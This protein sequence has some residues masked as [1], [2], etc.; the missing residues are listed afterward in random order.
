M[1]QKK[2]KEPLQKIEIKKK[3]NHSWTMYKDPN[4]RYW[5]YCNNCDAHEWVSDILN[6]RKE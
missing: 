6:T 5:N 4:G 2:I 3:H 1:K